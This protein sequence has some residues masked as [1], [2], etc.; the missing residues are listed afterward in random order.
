MKEETVSD[1]SVNGKA[2]CPHCGTT[3]RFPVGDQVQLRENPFAAPT[4]YVIRWVQCPECE[5]VVVSLIY[6]AKGIS[7]DTVIYPLNSLR[8]PVPPE[9]PPTIRADYDEAAQILSASPKGSA[10]LSRRCLQE[11]LVD[12]GGAKK[13]NLSGQ[14]DEVTPRLPTYLERVLDQVR[15]IGNFSAHPLKDTN[16]GEIVDVEPGEAEW[17]LDVLDEL[18]DFYYVKPAAVKRKTDQLNQ[19]LTAAGKPT[20]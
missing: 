10:A 4:G 1:F 17:N 13:K 11:V 5:N 12:A 7:R 14:I 16:S 6:E 3:V 18:F 2:R 15:V 20:I 9:V 8:D 19:K